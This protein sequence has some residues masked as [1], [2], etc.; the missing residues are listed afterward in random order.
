[1]TWLVT[2]GAGYIGA[3][4]LRALQ[5]SGREVVVLDDLSTGVRAKVP[6][7]VAL[8]ECSV[9]DGG[10]VAAAM[11]EYG[12]T[13][14]VHLAAKKAVGES[15]EQP[16]FYYRENVDGMRSLLDAMVS[17]GV[18]DIVYSSSAAV[19]GEQDVPLVDESAPLLSAS[20]YGRTKVIGEWMLADV[21]AAHGI[22]WV[23]LRYFNVVG[24]GSDD[25]GDTSAN[26]LVPLAMRAVSAGL[27]PKVFG[28]D[29]P[30]PDGTCIRDYVDVRDLAE[31][32]V[33][34]AARAEAGAAAEVYNVGRGTGVSV[35]EVLAE[36]GRVT[37]AMLEP[38]VTPRRPGDPAVLVASADR[39]REEL[40]WSASYGLEDMVASAWSAW[41][42]SPAR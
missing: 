39:F 5:A 29:Y 23:A 13:G 14:V 41:Q 28:D 11:R 9:L 36:V 17:A 8:V 18:R 1:M 34:A 25:L 16:L 6:A 26:N 32:H 2:G 20:P 21:A 3:H 24:A 33:I 22:S 7:G 4:V 35:R 12:V 30:T 40:G 37:G 10:A 19:Y 38:V 15:V 27:A 42:A 31:S